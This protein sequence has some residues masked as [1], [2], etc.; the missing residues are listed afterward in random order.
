MKRLHFASIGG[1]SAAVAALIVS[2]C[3]ALPMALVFAG[4][5]TSVVGLLAPLYALRPIFLTVAGIL[6]ALGWYIAIRHGAK[7]TYFFLALG[8]ALVMAALAWAWWDPLLQRLVMQL[9]R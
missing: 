3:C 2:S 8:T 1:V 4:V 7:R 5:S 9:A 6:L